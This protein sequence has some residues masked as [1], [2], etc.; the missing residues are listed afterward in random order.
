MTCRYNCISNI[1]LHCKLLVQVSEAAQ[2]QYH[3]VA[4]SIYTCD[5]AAT[6]SLEGRAPSRAQQEHGA[7]RSASLPSTTA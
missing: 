7:L 3:G 4:I 5:A 1:R 6:T 2:T